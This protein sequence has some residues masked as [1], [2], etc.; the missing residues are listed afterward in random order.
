MYAASAGSDCTYGMS[1]TP[2]GF[3]TAPASS[4]FTITYTGSIYEGLQSADMLLSLL[5]ELINEHEINPAHLQLHYA[6]KTVTF[7]RRGYN[8]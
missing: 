4:H 5:R 8:A 2:S 3:L 1:F 7:G 6:G